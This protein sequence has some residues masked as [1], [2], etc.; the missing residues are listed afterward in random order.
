MR[1]YQRMAPHK[2]TDGTLESILWNKVPIELQQEVK[3]ITDGSV[4]ELLQ[5]L[6]RAEAVLAERKRRS[7]YPEIA[8]KIT[9]SSQERGQGQINRSTTRDHGRT[10]RRSTISSSAT[11]EM[12]SREVKCFNCHKKG[13]IA[14]HCPNFGTP[15]RTPVR[16]MS[17]ATV[18]ANGTAEKEESEKV[19][20]EQMWK[21]T[22]ILSTVDSKDQNL[23]STF[24]IVGPTYKVD[25]TVDGIKTRALLDHGSQVTIVRQQLLP[26]VKE[27]QEWSMDTCQ[28][29]VVPL[30]SQPVGA[31]GQELGAVGIAML[32]ILIETTGK[33]CPIPC[34]VLDS[35]RPLWSGELEDCGVLMGTNALVKHGFTV[36]HSDGTQVEP[37]CKDANVSTTSVKVINVL[38][39]KT[40]HLKPHQSKIIQTVLEVE[41]MTTT[42]DFMISPNETVPAERNCDVLVTVVSG[43]VNKVTIR[44]NNWGGS[45]I[46]IKKGSKIAV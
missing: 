6:L 28:T 21:W 24:P 36:T 32:N 12:S 41:M 26:M 5:R 25:V 3:E 43:N 7:Q 45:P 13:H 18:S 27:K 42:G 8:S 11:G 22:R 14:K 30:K 31:T 16:A 19:P 17:T 2:L 34:Y 15:P 35:N 20:N 39:D 37:N 4:Q 9:S 40:V 1:D 10:G 38:L 29:K 46:V 44:L 23:S 33:T